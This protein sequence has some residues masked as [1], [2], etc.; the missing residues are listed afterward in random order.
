[1]NGFLC[2]DK[3]Q[4]ITSRDAVN[5]VQRRVKPAKV[6]HAG[7][8]DPMAT[9][10]LVVAVG[11]TTRL[12]PYVQRSQKQYLAKFE[13]GKKS[14]TEDMTGTVVDCQVLR[15]PE[16]DEVAVAC[17]RFIGDIMQ[18]PPAFSALHVNGKRAYDLARK[19]KKVELKDR[20]I[21][22]HSIDL[23]DF[24]FP[25]F[26]IDIRCG[27]GTYVRSLG[28]DIGE[29]LGCG[30]VMSE[31]RRTAVGKFD[32]ATS[33]T[34]D[35][36]EDKSAIQRHCISAVTGVET[37]PKVSLDESSVVAL[38]FGQKVEVNCEDDEIAAISSEG[39]LLAVLARTSGNVFRPAINFV[40]K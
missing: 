26:R 20:P 24:N 10:V 6:G 5:H 3:P 2:I 35:E 25:T 31:L 18:R 8:L 15:I 9:G 16:Y 11:K 36:L 29:A 21:V 33:S 30:A 7:T 38:S 32:L 13:L 14:D 40:A 12:V 34:L 37:L 1:M 22:I 19:G 39:E 4:G 23:V 28:R 27:S 17:Q